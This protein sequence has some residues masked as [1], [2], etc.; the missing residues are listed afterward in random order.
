M[1]NIQLRVKRKGKEVVGRGKKIFQDKLTTISMRNMMGYIIH[2][3][4][5]TKI[6][7]GL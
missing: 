2:L 5:T 4:T 1:R 7:C 3:L 6:H